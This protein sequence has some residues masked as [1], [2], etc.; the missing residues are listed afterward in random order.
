MTLKA[1]DL[2]SGCG[3][4]S[5]GLKD[6]GF[7]VVAAVEIDA[8]AQETYSLNHPEVALYGADIRALDPLSVA[9]AAKLQPGEL[10]LLA[11]CPP[12]QGFSRLRTKNQK[13]SVQDDRNDLVLDFYRFVVALLPKTVMLEN[14][15]ALMRD[16]RFEQLR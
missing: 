1:I 11:G 5:Q 7:S 12:C 14:V 8:K 2:F 4:L 10:D 13:T 6:A 3:G 9:L 16:D 15:P